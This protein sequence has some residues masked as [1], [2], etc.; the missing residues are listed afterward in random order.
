MKC[1]S[2]LDFEGKT[3]SLVGYGIS[4]QAMLD[5]LMKNGV[6]P[7]VR[8]EKSTIL[9]K[10]ILGIFS[11]DYMSACEDIVFRSPSVRGDNFS[12]NARVY[13]EI[14]FSLETANCYKIGVTGSDGK[15]TTSTLIHKILEKTKK[16]AYLVGNI[17]TPL[18]SYLDKIKKDDFL[19][20]ELSSFQLYDYTPS[21]DCAVITSISPN[22]L[23][24]HTSLAEYVFSKRNI[25][26]RSK[27]AVVNYDSP[28]RDF[29][30]HDDITYFSLSDKSRMVGNGANYVYIKDGFVYYNREQL[31]NCSLIKLRGEYNLLNIL[32][33]IGVVYN[34]GSLDSIIDVASTF[35][36][37]SHRAELIHTK[38]GISFIDSSVDS[39]PT[40]TKAT[41][42]IYPKERS[43]VILGG[44]DKNLSYDELNE[45]TNG[46]KCAIL[47]G[48]NR[49][50]IYKAI[51]NSAKKIIIVNNLADAV[52]ASYKEANVGN[53]V[54]LSPASA[55][56]D[57]F[58][59][60]KERAQRFNDLVKS[61]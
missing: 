38:N 60:Y 54:I 44:Y 35:E 28:Y 27:R 37:V 59:N 13:T 26:K 6:Y 21:L 32:A 56:F 50:K 31:F 29:F 40:R 42:S 41:L 47:L 11:S 30:M 52:L 39:T 46:I 51:D 45:A 23:D 16:S 58:K 20:C 34:Y 17:G 48:E 61:L 14:G 15:T 8:S 25:L 57:M 4:N 5:Y 53:F 55:S 10:G 3:V 19:V 49:E 36:G 1:S 24:W 43:I 22:H 12:K 9:P 2:I 18:V 7:T 33:S